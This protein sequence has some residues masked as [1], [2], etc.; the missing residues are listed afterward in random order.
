[1]LKKRGAYPKSG[2][3]LVRRTHRVPAFLIDHEPQTRL[4]KILPTTKPL[5]M[6]EKLQPAK[7][8]TKQ[9]P[10]EVKIQLC[11]GTKLNQRT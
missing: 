2:A 3:R 7:A 6:I 11:K 1:M 10:D 8:L 4:N 5:A 9:I